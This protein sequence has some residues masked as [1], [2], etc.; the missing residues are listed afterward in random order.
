MSPEQI[1]EVCHEAN[2]ALTKHVGDVEVQP[3]WSEAAEE[4]RVSSINGVKFALEHPEA[5]PADQHNAWASDKVKAGWKYGPVKN[6]ELKTHPA[7]VDYDDLPFGTKAKDA[8]FR[9]VVAALRPL[10]K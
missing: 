3:P 2:R 7:L 4:M 6:A 10:A 9:N 1:A 5:T 8:L